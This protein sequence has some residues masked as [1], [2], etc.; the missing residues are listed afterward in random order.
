MTHL[1]QLGDLSPLLTAP[2]DPKGFWSGLKSIIPEWSVPALP[3][4][5]HLPII[6]REKRVE[7]RWGGLH[8]R[9]LLGSP[10]Q[11]ILHHLPNSHCP[12]AETFG[13]ISWNPTYKT[14]AESSGWRLQAMRE[15]CLVWAHPPNLPASPRMET[16]REPSE[17]HRD[18]LCPGG[19]ETW[20]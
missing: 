10:L 6:A 20:V 7:L 16:P 17:N 2:D 14:K 9:K 18:K 4:S 8:S 19:Q 1:P 5:I 3:L 13:Q 12:S 11:C 15:S